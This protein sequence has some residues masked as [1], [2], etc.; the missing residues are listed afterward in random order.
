MQHHGVDDDTSVVLE[1]LEI[2]MV[3]KC[4]HFICKHSTNK[5]ES[6]SV[7]I[8]VTTN[9]WDLCILSYAAEEEG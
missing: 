9:V 3:V 6:F 1:L 8:F 2:T 5:L 7:H 4:C